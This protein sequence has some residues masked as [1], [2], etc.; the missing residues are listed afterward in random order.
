MREGRGS[1]KCRRV[2]GEKRK[3]GAGRNGRAAGV[4]EN[5]CGEI[6]QSDSLEVKNKW[7]GQ[8]IRK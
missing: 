5:V 3:G 7:E 4:R 2:K 6:R 8:M 1:E